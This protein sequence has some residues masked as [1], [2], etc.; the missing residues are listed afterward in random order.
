MGTLQSHG[1]AAVALLRHFGNMD[2]ATLPRTPNAVYFNVL[3]RLVIHYPATLA[4]PLAGLA[5]IL[6]VVVL[7]LGLRRRQISLGG[8]GVGALGLLLSLILSV[9]LVTLAW[10]LIRLLN[11]NL[12]VM[13]VGGWYREPLYLWAFVALSIFVVGGLHL[14]WRRWFRLM[15]L[16][17][18]ALGWWVLLALLTATMLTGFSA[19]FTWPLLAALLALGWTLWRPQS[20]KHA[21]AQVGIWFAPT[22]ISLA[23]TVPLIAMLAIYAGRMEAILGLPSMALPIPVIVLLLGLLLPVLEWIAPKRRRWLPVG[24]LFVS[25]VLVLTATGLSGFDAAHPKPN[26]VIYW[27]DANQ[28]QARWITVDDAR[29]GRDT[30]AQL[31]EW[32]GQFFPDGGQ[33]S[34]INPWLSGW[35]T[36]QFPALETSAPVADL[37]SSSLTLLSD[38]SAGTVRHLRL[39]VDIPEAVQ[40]AHILVQASKPMAALGVNGSAVDLRSQSVESMQ[41][42]VLGRH[43]D[44]VT[45]QLTVSTGASVAITVQD[46]ILG[47]P[48]I[49]GLTLMPR[50]E[51]MMPAPWNDSADSSIVLTRSEWRN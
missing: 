40:D 3:P 29:S 25:L 31:D 14:F 8:V 11:P 36:T 48:S 44:G 12:H 32:T 7:V 41:I 6:F 15:D 16:T 10:W 43:P 26:T 47:L 18:G 42:N 23:L 13:T 19:I 20:A 50:P 9:T 24:A 5:A 17:V 28:N 33:E 46:R 21:W 1:N 49:P 4:L 37:P 38:E 35:F 27:L 22:L 30:R 2:L 39:H 45:L 51:W 34:S